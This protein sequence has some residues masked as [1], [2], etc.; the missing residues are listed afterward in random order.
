MI[1]VYMAYIL[2]YAHKISVFNFFLVN[3]TVSGAMPIVV[4]EAWL[5][6]GC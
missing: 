4:N 1:I 5:S 6:E 2:N 3:S